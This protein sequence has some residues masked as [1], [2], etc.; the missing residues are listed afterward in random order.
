MTFMKALRDEVK[1]LKNAVAAEKK[2]RL[3]SEKLLASTDAT[4]KVNLDS[5]LEGHRLA[6][7][8]LQKDVEARDKEIAR[9]RTRLLQVEAPE[10]GPDAET[11]RLRRRLAELVNELAAAGS[12]SPATR[13]ITAPLADS[14]PAQPPQPRANGE[15]S[16]PS[17]ETF[18]DRA[19]ADLE[20]QI[21]LLLVRAD[22]AETSGNREAARWNYQK[23]LEKDPH[24]QRALVRV[25]N[26]L[27]DAGD[28]NAAERYLMRAFYNNPDDLELLTPL[29][30]LLAHQGK[31]DMAV[32]MLSRATA[33][34]PDNAQ[35]HR[36]LGVACHSLGWTDAA[37]KQFLRSWKLDS[38]SADTAFNLAVLLA[39]KG[40]SHRPEAR[41]WYDKARALGGVADPQLE[42]LLPQ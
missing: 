1:T 16:N 31:A 27:A 36:D 22:Q 28:F 41:R 24:R 40:D 30:F 2:L 19:A 32:S 26:I 21:E 37:E 14:N 10:Q 23:V 9:L 17:S 34:Y 8:R 29:G 20:A 6:V 33:L 35:H 11:V 42:R 12:S 13:P 38:S 18:A 7:T 25:G 15:D 39:N 4:A 5:E 3:E